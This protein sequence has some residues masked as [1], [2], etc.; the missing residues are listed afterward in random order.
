MAVPIG[1]SG[2]ATFTFN[3]T[4]HE[5]ITATATDTTTG[6]TSEFSLIDTDVDGL[7]DV[8]EMADG[9]DFDEDGNLTAN[10]KILP[11]SNRL[12][13]DVYVEVDAMTGFAPGAANF[14]PMVN[15]SVPA[16]FAKAL[17][18]NVHN[19]DQ[20]DGVTLHVV[21]DQKNLPVVDFTTVDDPFADFRP[22]KNGTQADHKDGSFGT[23]L[24][25]NDPNWADIRQR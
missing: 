9:L 10:E 11:G 1:G 13:K 22:V 2:D 25:H 24:Q 17:D 6:S 18:S 4:G 19:P 16:A 8:W 21:Y 23:A 12:H 5:F 7:C 20:M 3:H 14:D 15:T